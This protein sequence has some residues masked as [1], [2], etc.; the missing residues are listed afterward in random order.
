MLRDDAHRRFAVEAEECAIGGDR[1]GLVAKIAMA[2]AD[3]HVGIG[4]S[5]IEAEHLGERR[6]RL[7]VPAERLQRARIL[8]AVVRVFRLQRNGAGIA[9]QSPFPL[10][11]DRL[12]TPV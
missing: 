5:G 1:L 7:I 11:Q 12:D 8:I 10:L 6:Q 3:R 4:K 2:V 9:R